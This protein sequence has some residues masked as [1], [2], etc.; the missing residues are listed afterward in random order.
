MKFINDY[1]FRLNTNKRLR[2]HP[3]KCKHMHIGK[4]G[5]NLNQTYTLRSTITESVNE[6]KDIGVHI[7]HELSFDKQISEKVNKA[8]AIFALLRRTFRC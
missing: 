2:F 8:N 7:D 3:E 4:P 1:V 6:E 5:P